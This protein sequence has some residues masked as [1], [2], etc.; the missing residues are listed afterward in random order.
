[1][2]KPW[3]IQSSEIL[4]KDRWIHL[5]AD[6]CVNAEG[7]EIAPFYVLEY[8]EFVNVIAITDDGNMIL[9]REYRHGGGV[10][11]LGFP[12][13]VMDRDDPDPMVAAKRELL[14]ETGYS[15][16]DWTSLGAL[17]VNWANQNNRIHYFLARHAN[18][19]A[20]QQLDENE[21]ID[22]VPTPIAD[23]LKPGHLLHSHNVAGLMLAYPYLT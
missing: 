17:Y 22:V 8:P 19:T 23:A 16:D 21:E 13:G 3:L 11:G 12:A 6:S 5:R 4:V 9:I 20:Q 1:M 10:V 14:E 7:R 2:V 18:P 15:S